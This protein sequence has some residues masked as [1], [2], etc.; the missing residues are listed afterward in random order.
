MSLVI[1][2]SKSVS[3]PLPV[4]ES[5]ICHGRLSVRTARRN[6]RLQFPPGAC[7]CL[8]DSE[9]Y[10]G[11]FYI[12]EK[13]RQLSVLSRRDFNFSVSR[14]FLPEPFKPNLRAHERATVVE[15]FERSILF[16]AYACA[17]AR[18]RRA[19]GNIFAPVQCRLQH[20]L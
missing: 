15:S 14:L 18:V 16:Y 9:S 12:V 2:L 19:E 1:C 5:P 10:L 3:S 11:E 7:A 17:R 20:R 4:E 8:S 13:W 6:G